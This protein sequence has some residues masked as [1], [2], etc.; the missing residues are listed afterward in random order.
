[1]F[2]LFLFY[3]SKPRHWFSFSVTL[4]I[5]ERRTN[6]PEDT[7][8]ENLQRLESRLV[9][10]EQVQIKTDSLASVEFPL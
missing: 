3:K 5:G 9:K 1:M 2:E 8:Q 10:L 4:Q 6:A 7:F